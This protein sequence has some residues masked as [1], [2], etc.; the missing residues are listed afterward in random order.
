MPILQKEYAYW[1]EAKE[2]TVVI[3]DDHDIFIL[4][5]YYTNWTHPRPESFVQDELTAWVL[6]Q[7]LHN[8]TV[9]PESTMTAEETYT[10]EAALLFAKE[11]ATHHAK[12]LAQED[13][14]NG[15]DNRKRQRAFKSIPSHRAGLAAAARVSSRDSEDSYSSSSI[16]GDETYRPMSTILEG[17][18][19]ALPPPPHPM[20]DNETVVQ[21]LYAQLAAA[22]ETGWDFSSRWFQ[23]RND[24]SSVETMNLVPVDLNAILFAVEVELS[25]FA[26]VLDDPVLANHFEAAY[27]SRRQ[28]IHEV[29][30]NAT[31]AQWQDWHIDHKQWRD[32]VMLSNFV[33]LWAKCYDESVFCTFILACSRSISWW[34][35]LFV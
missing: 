20:H 13:L 15:S 8:E 9:T 14:R 31:A 16:N 33:P 21:T 30:W 1:M 19:A 34:K 4:N 28:A 24:L 32:E 7:R 12:T 18:S 5:K 27:T 35:A 23:D 29:L 25:D 3:Q 2:R 10:P 17:M 22:A 6:W 26:L 11:F